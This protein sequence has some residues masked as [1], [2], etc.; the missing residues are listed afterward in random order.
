MMD[1]C[2]LSGEEVGRLLYYK[3]TPNHTEHVHIPCSEA[4]RLLKLEDLELVTGWDGRS[5]V[6]TAKIHFL[7]AL[8]SGPSHVKVIQ[9]LVS[10]H[11]TELRP[12]R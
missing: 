12:P 2:V 10:N 4:I 8:P 7:H 5:Y 6:T 1:C 11:I 9:R 3:I